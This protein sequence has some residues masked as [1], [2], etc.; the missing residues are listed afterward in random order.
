MHLYLI[1]IETYKLHIGFEWILMPI[2]LLLDMKL[3]QTHEM[4]IELGD[5]IVALSLLAL[6]V[7]PPNCRSLTH[8]LMFLHL[9]LY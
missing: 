3:K 8:H 1:L 6:D 4:C 7:K 9:N 2:S 5:G